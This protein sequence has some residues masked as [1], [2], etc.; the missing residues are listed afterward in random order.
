MKIIYKNIKTGKY[1][2]IAS[3]NIEY[4]SINNRYIIDYDETSNIE[5]AFDFNDKF[6]KSLKF[7]ELHYKKLTYKQEL[8]KIKLEK[9]NENN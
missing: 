5:K 1:L 7:N 2:R 4:D 9:L 6:F 3:Q 8:R